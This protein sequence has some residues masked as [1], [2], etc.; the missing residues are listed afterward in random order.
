[1]V[2]FMKHHLAWLAYA[3][4]KT[5]KGIGLGT[6]LSLGGWKGSQFNLKFS[7]SQPCTVEVRM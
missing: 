6:L 4:M 7:L 5:E 1:M 2:K 3:G